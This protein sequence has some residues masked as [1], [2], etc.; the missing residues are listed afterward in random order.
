VEPCDKIESLTPHYSPVA[1]VVF[2]GS[3]YPARS[4]KKKN[5]AIMFF[6][7]TNEWYVIAKTTGESMSGEAQR[8]RTKTPQT[9]LSRY[10]PTY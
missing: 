8:K 5:I 3:I 10:S 2:L 7:P 9:T 4:Q 6:E 1:E